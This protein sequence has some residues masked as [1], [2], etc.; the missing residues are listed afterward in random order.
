MRDLTKDQR[1]G[2]HGLIHELILDAQRSKQDV[3]Q[4]AKG[5]AKLFEQDIDDLHTTIE[6]YRLKLKSTAQQELDAIEDR[7]AALLK[8][9]DS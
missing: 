2:L 5:I 3:G 8:V 4:C 1:D 6:A 9:V 7:K